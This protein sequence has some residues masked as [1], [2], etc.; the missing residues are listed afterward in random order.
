MKIGE[1]S[2]H[3]FIVKLKF[4]GILIVLLM[5]VTLSMYEVNKIPPKT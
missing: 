4:R 1:A 2:I 3:L 5:P